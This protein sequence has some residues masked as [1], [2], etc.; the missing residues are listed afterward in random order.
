VLGSVAT[1]AHG[2]LPVKDRPA[3]RFKTHAFLG[4]PPGRSAR[5]GG[6]A[7]PEVPGLIRVIHG[8]RPR[9]NMFML[10]P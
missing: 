2:N 4:E 8:H 3:A 7:G 6:Y 5:L 9:L 10:P 1:V